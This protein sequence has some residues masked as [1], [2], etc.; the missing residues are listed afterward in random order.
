MRVCMLQQLNFC[1]EHE[2]IEK[3]KQKTE[4]KKVNRTQDNNKLKDL[5][6]I[7]IAWQYY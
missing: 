4:N 7:S 1:I 6:L 2:L 3:E 5:L